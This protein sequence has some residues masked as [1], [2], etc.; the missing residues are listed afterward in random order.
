MA[1]A[2][3]VGSVLAVRNSYKMVAL[4]RQFASVRQ[5][6]TTESGLLKDIH[7]VLQQVEHLLRERPAETA[8]TTAGK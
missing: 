3:V 4:E 6:A 1:E 7:G 5:A 8:E 2:G